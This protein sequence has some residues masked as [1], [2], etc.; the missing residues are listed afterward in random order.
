MTQYDI[1]RTEGIKYAGSKLK[2]IPFI[3]ECIE[4]FAFQNVLDGFAGTTRVGQVFAQRGMAVT[5]NDISAWSEVFGNCYFK[6]ERP[7]PFYEKLIEELNRMDG[8]NGWFTQ[9]YG[10]SETDTKKP[11]QIHNTMKLDAIRDHIDTLDLS[12][13]DKCV[14]LTSLIL[15]MDA[16]D[17]TIGHFSSYLSEWSD[18]SYHTMKMKLPRRFP[19][20][21]KKH[22]VLKGDIFDAIR[23]KNYDFAYLDPPYGSN[24]EKM[25]P[26]RVRY[27]AYYH[28]WTSIILNDKPELFGK[29][30]RRTD[31]KDTVSSSVFEEFRKDDTGHFIAI[32]AIDK[33]LREV[34]ADYVMLSYSSG[35][36]ATKQDLTDCIDTRGKLVKAVEID[37]RKNVMANMKWTNEWTNDTRNQEYLF[38]I[39]K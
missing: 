11:F 17:S 2:I 14:L 19:T 6:S 12:F 4:P 20:D 3:L 15:A 22:T 39:K 26:S 33:M 18:R 1:P 32:N 13:P 10:G 16:V 34:Q 37:Y 28:I 24:N 35:G 8:V 5:S 30:C 21:T 38:L 36:R 9:N 25:P 7:D 29:V 23:Y 31:S 27:S